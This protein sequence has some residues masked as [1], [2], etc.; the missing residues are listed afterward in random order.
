MLKYLSKPEG[1]AIGVQDIFGSGLCYREPLV[2]HGV[3]DANDRVRLG[4]LEENNIYT[5]YIV[6][7]ISSFHSTI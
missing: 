4:L 3:N 1:R 7:I 5:V 2:C 6:N